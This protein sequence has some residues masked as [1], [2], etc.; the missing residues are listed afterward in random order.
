MKQITTIFA[1]LFCSAIQAQTYYLQGTTDS[2]LGS[3]N[4]LL[5]NNTLKIGNSSSAAER[6]KNMLKIGDGDYIQIGEW[7]ADNL[8]SFKASK[9]NFTNGYV[10]IG[11]IGGASL[12]A[13]LDIM[14]T[15]T[16][17]TK[18]ILA[19]LSESG[20]TKHLSV[21]SYDTQPINSKMF[22][23]EHQFFNVPN[24]AINFHRGNGAKDGFITFDCYGSQRAKLYHGGLE[25]NGAI[26]ADGDAFI[27]GSLRLSGSGSAGSSLLLY[28][29]SKTQ[30]GQAIGW[31]MFNMTGEHG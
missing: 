13:C 7:E 16:N 17:K 22:A 2:S 18:A 28:N 5:H 9:F 29:T 19:R 14:N 12:Q 21:K 30:A 26:K 27:Q 10:G 3:N 24:S 11:G 1:I 4:V 23:I 31:K 20:M 8:L 25:V 15:T 6:I